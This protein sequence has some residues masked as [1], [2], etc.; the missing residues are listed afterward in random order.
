[1]L[2]G[3]RAAGDRRNFISGIAAAGLGA[4]SCSS[5]GGFVSAFA[6]TL[7][8]AKTSLIDVHHHFVPPFYLSENRDRIVAAGG[9]TC[10]DYGDC[11]SLLREPDAANSRSR[12]TS[13]VVRTVTR[14]ITAAPLPAD[15]DDRRHERDHGAWGSTRQ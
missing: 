5:V 13:R 2:R 9:V 15:R 12:T 7:V 4:L 1:M 8:V 10:D 3:V 11:V 6:Q 14:A